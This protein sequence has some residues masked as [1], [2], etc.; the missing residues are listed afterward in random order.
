M[1]G[2]FLTVGSAFVVDSMSSGRAGAERPMVNWDV[3]GKN[4]RDLKVYLHDQWGKW[5]LP[6]SE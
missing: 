5:S 6:K 4:L 2:A 3:V 1:L